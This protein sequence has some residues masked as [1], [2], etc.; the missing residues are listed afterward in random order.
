MK[1]ILVLLLLSSTTFIVKAQRIGY[2]M[3]TNG[4]SYLYSDYKNFELRHRTDSKE[5]RITY[6]QNIKLDNHITL[7]IPLHYKIENNLPTLEPRFV[8]KQNNTSVWV[9][10]EFGTDRLYNFAVAVDIKD[11][12]VYYRVGWDSSNTVRFRVL[13]KIN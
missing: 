13:I 1:K 7:S 5:N 8:Y 12:N 3:R 9:Q 11:N 6:R 10:Q 4:K 2:E